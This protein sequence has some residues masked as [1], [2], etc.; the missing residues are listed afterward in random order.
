MR[1]R[2]GIEHRRLGE[3]STPYSTNHN[4][5]KANTSREASSNEPKM[6]KNTLNTISPIISLPSNSSN[7]PSRHLTPPFTRPSRTPSMNHFRRSFRT[8]TQSTSSPISLLPIR[9]ID[10]YASSMLLLCISALLPMIGIEMGSTTI[11]ISRFYLPHDQIDYPLVDVRTTKKSLTSQLRR[12]KPQSNPTVL[13]CI[14]HAFPTD[15]PRQFNNSFHPR[16]NDPSTAN[17]INSIPY[18]PPLLLRLHASNVFSALSFH[19][20]PSKPIPIH[21]RH[22]I[23]PLLFNIPPN[24]AN[25]CE[26]S[27]STTPFLFSS[28]LPSTGVPPH[29]HSLRKEP[30]KRERCN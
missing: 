2:R 29:S 11:Q 3:C 26:S 5:M 12:W 4:T 17:Q 28:Q 19:I 27:L 24:T 30:R 13:F 21:A 1:R 23:C 6:M 7:N 18:V 22:G 15:A 10:P 20:D 9:Q 14:S 8:D 25:S 16:N